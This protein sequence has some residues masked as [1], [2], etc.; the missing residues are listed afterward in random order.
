MTPLPIDSHL[1]EIARR[2]MESKSLVIVAAPG[3]GKT[4]R[5]PPAIL[6]SG[7]L[8]SKHPNL[9]MLQPRRIAAR[10]AAQR[11]ADENGWQVGRQV[12][13]HIRFE[14]R[15]GPQT[16]LRV[17]TE[18]VLT[19]KLLDDPFLQGIG[20]VVLDEFHERSIHSDLALA[21]LA[22]MR[23]VRDDLHIIVM[24]AT[25]AA[26]AA[27]RFLGGCPIVDVPGRAF[28][29]E[30]E[31]RPQAGL[32]LVDRVT[33]TVV[34]EVSRNAGDVLVF[35]PGAPEIRRISRLLESLA[36]AQHLSILPLH[37]S[38]PPEE[39]TLALRPSPKRK[40]ILATNIAETS[41][42]I[43]GVT[44]VI[45][46]GLARV[47]IFDANRGLDRLELKRIS[48]ASAAQ[49]AGRAG[50]TAPGRCVRLW[51]AKEQA[52]LDEFELPEVHRVDLCA[53]VLDLHAWGKSDPRDFGWF[54]RPSPAALDSAQRILEM[55]G[56][57]DQTGRL[58]MS[59]KRLMKLPVHPRIARLLCAAADAGCPDEGAGLAALLSEKDILGRRVSPG[60]PL[61]QGQSDLLLRLDLLNDSRRRDQLEPAVARQVI[62][63]RNELQRLARR[64]RKPSNI[65]PPTDVLLKLM[66]FA[67]PDRVCR[68][69]ASDPSAALM[70]G[71]GGVRLAADSVVRQDEFF[72]ALDVSHDPRSP[73]REALVH[74]ASAIRVEWLM[75]LFPHSIT[76]Q[77]TT[78]FDPQRQSVV[79]LGTVRYRDLVISEDRNARVDAH[80][81]GQ[82]L[83]A[84]LRPRAAEIFAADEQAARLLARVDLLRRWMPE[85]P[86]PPMDQSQLAPVIEE[87]CRGKR[88][89]KDVENGPLA[90]ILEALLPFPLDTLLRQHAPETIQVPSGSRIRIS[91]AAGQPPVLAVR[92][93][94]I[95]GLKDTPRI[96]AGR[97]PIILHLLGPHWRPVQITDDLRSFWST[98]YFQVRKD[99]RVRYPRHSWPD[100]PLTA[101]PQAKG[102]RRQKL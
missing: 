47:P 7:L 55:L 63:A 100:D 75:E 36:A 37:G 13:Y 81:A 34:E 21:M 24:S 90:A 102:A 79:S 92:I 58:S 84:V 94:E 41:L 43:D 26:E 44:L 46:S 74:I 8:S 67:Y 69:R 19:R 65:P 30:I 101:A 72:L 39:Q 91:Y 99:L 4:T 52:A 27:S 18:G 33:A 62:P 25:L 83:A 48:K 97:L 59:G 31:Y 76:R 87:L 68:R 32:G 78:V 3:A 6:R 50:R 16:R 20:A 57:V 35:L 38:L 1:P 95:F 17:L 23:A 9:V 40:V 15:L 49:R 64:L 77:R 28:P 42:T 51:S 60:G 5:V 10:A 61:V 80:E 88:S 56:A 86:W 89:V 71:G 93:Q 14:K 2:L 82:T 11:I 54:D 29:V 70:V 96:A 73:S 98:A 45:D 53:T 12:G 22:E 85:H 66:L